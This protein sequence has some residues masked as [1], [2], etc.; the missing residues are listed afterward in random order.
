[1]R[2]CYSAPSRVSFCHVVTHTQRPPT[3]SL[4]NLVVYLGAKV[5]QFLWTSLRIDGIFN[6]KQMKL[7]LWGMK[8]QSIQWFVLCCT[9]KHWK[10]GWKTKKRA[11][12]INCDL[13]LGLGYDGIHRD[14]GIKC[15]SLEI[16]LYRFLSVC[17]YPLS[18]VLL[19]VIHVRLIKRHAWMT[20]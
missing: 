8:V 19:K 7:K 2:F 9:T 3:F 1:M 14:C 16:L 10:Y 13:K 5:L 17:I 15:L 4:R 20:K 18:T 11:M 6:L 12:K